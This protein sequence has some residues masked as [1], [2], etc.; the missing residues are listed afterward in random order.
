MSTTDDP[1]L[2]DTCEQDPR[3]PSGRWRG[4]YIQ[5]GLKSS[6]EFILHFNN[7]IVTGMGCDPCGVFAVTG[8]YDLKSARVRMKKAYPGRGYHVEYD[9]NAEIQH[10]IWGLWHIPGDDRGGFQIRPEGDAAN[11]AAETLEQDLPTPVL[12]PVLAN[13]GTVSWDNPF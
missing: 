8:D 5:F 13:A 11:G 12:E 1:R 6:Q 2:D 9:G 3:L 10:G 4:H 7:G